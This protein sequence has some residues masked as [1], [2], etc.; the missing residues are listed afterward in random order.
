MAFF[1]HDDVAVAAAIEKHTTRA[2]TVGLDLG[3]TT[4]PTAV[5][6]L[7]RLRVPRLRVGKVPDHLKF[8]ESYRVRHLER[9]PLRTSYPEIVVHVGRMLATPP[10]SPGARLVIDHTG[11]GRPVFDLFKAAKLRP[12]GVTITAGDGWT[13]DVGNFRVSKMILVSRLQ[14]AL[15]SGLLQV[16]AGLPEADALKSELSDFRVN[17]GASGYAAFGARTGRHDDLVLAIA[18][19]LWHAATVGEEKVTVGHVLWG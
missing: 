19:G 18:I 10:L 2:Y 16:A 15:H 4:D 6:V 14:A 13:R 8:D 3:Q 9:L 1:L 5:A 12:I 17:Y 7:E 11:V